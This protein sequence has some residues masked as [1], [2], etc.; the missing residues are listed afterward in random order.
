MSGSSG[1]GQFEE[2]DESEHVD[3]VVY[4]KVGFTRSQVMS[5]YDSVMPWL[6]PEILMRP[7]SL[8]R[9]PDGVRAD[10][11]STCF[12]Q[13]HFAPQFGDQV[14]ALPM[15][16]SRGK[17]VEFMYVSGEVGTRDLLQM[18]TLEF[19]P[20]GAKVPTVEKADRLTLDLDPG[21]GVGWKKIVAAAELIHH[22]LADI[23]LQSFVKLSGGKGLHV[24]VPLKP[25]QPWEIAK[26]F[27]RGIAGTLTKLRPKEFIEVAT[28]SRRTGRIFVDYLRNLRGATT[29]AA[30]S[31]RARESASIAMPVSW[32]E[33]RRIESASAFNMSNVA[34]HLA[35]RQGDPWKSIDEIEQTIRG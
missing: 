7:M 14:S 24:V 35:Q 22:M 18:N 25:A 12:F 9:C 23:G 13:K 28:K 3:C 15:N 33:I 34:A 30:Y 29:I 11:E 26:Q 8:L 5:Y 20:W 16:D 4:A 21:H 31:L 6:L 19:H 2:S 32:E 1:N 27:C 17:R 10:A